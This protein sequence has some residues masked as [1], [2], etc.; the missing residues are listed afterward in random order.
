M[1]VSSHLR[2]WGTF[3]LHPWRS[4]RSIV[5]CV[6]L[7]EDRKVEVETELKQSETQRQ[8]FKHQH[9][10][11]ISLTELLLTPFCV[12]LSLTSRSAE[13]TAVFL[14]I[15][16]LSDRKPREIKM[17]MLLFLLLMG[18]VGPHCT[19]AL[20]NFPEFVA[21]G[22]VD[23]VEITHYDSNTTRAKPKQDW[24]KKITDEVPQYWEEQTQGLM[25]SQQVYK[26][27]IETV[28]QRLNQTGG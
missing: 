20:T 9:R 13:R 3:S 17:K 14:W 19:S 27:G 22:L 25:G 21:V 11:Y 24:M 10:C 6:A 12:S 15:K 7:Q 5:P 26:V 8:V 28:K 18:I 23:E 4:N 16:N 1:S 2:S